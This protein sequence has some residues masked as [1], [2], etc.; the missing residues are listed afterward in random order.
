MSHKSLKSS[1]PAPRT[2]APSQLRKM[3]R[4]EHISAQVIPRTA[5][6][7]FTACGM[8]VKAGEKYFLVAAS[9]FPGYA[10]I[11]TWNESG[12][13]GCACGKPGNCDHRIAA[14]QYT[15]TH[16]KAVKVP[17]RKDI[18]G[19]VEWYADQSNQYE[20]AREAKRAEKALVAEIKSEFASVVVDS[21]A[22]S[23]NAQFGKSVVRRG[24]FLLSQKEAA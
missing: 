13:D 12:I 17:A 5:R 24:I 4:V 6:Q 23:I 11:V 22:A 10:Y 14:A 1:N 2:I 8:S 15:R 9:R 20:A 21:I 3:V 7:D 18:P 16:V 19:T